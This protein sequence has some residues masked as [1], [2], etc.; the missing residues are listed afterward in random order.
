M[1]ASAL[2]AIAIGAT[3]TSACGYRAETLPRCFSERVGP[4]LNAVKQVIDSGLYRGGDVE[5]THSLCTTHNER[6][7]VAERLLA[8]SGYT[9][10]RQ[11]M[12]EL[13]RCTNVT[14]ETPLTPQAIEKQVTTF[15]G[16]AAAARV[17]YGNWSGTI[18]DRF[19]FV[20]GKYI[21]FTRG[22]EIPKPEPPNGLT[23]EFQ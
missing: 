14:V 1:K 8:A 21:S 12:P 5:L 2:A 16:M 9:F 15:C 7:V 3:L 22:N 6:L 13:G 20:A 11:Q 10:S 19:L 4:S 18:G 17:S 23:R